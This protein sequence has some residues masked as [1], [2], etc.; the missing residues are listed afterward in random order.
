MRQSS[1]VFDCAANFYDETRG[2][3][4]GIAEQVAAAIIEAGRITTETHLLE[5]GVGTGRVALPVAQQS[6]AKLIGVD[7]SSLMMGKMVEKRT[8]EQVEAVRGDVTQLPLADASFNVAVAAHIFHL[9][10][11]W[12][13]ALDEVRRVLK[14]DGVLLSVYTSTPQNI[15]TV[16]Y[17]VGRQT[18]N[19]VG[20]NSSTFLD[21]AGWRPAR[22][23][24]TVNYIQSSTPQVHI[25]RMRRRVWSSFWSL[26]DDEVQE[27]IDAV[28]DALTAANHPLDRPVETKATVTVTVYQPPA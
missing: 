11:D 6:G 7:L 16:G 5:I 20:F 14:P 25:D 22:P 23:A 8:V 18:S 2:Y 10:S 17:A 28:T 27:K 4:P 3:P 13:A 19:F 1:I 15:L 12:R 24:V 26:T 9:V 21:E